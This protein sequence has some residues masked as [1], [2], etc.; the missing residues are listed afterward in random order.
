L[1]HAGE[2]QVHIR[3]VAQDARTARMY[4]S[5]SLLRGFEPSPP[6]TS[7][8][9]VL[10]GDHE[11]ADELA[12]ELIPLAIEGPHGPGSQRW[13]NAVEESTDDNG[14]DESDDEY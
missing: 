3:K 13:V 4:R 2:S 14:G 8:A 6:V 7:D 1:A 12:N 5:G 11:L 10:A 9:S